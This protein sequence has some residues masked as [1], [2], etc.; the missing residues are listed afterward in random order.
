[1]TSEAQALTDI[2]AQIIETR[3]DETKISPSWIATQA[4]T[5]LDPDHHSIP[6][7]YLA[8]HLEMRQIARGLLRQ[9]FEDSDP[10]TDDGESLQHELFPSLQRRYPCVRRKGDEPEYVR[11]E[12]MTDADIDYNVTRMRRESM[13]KLHHADALIAYQKRRKSA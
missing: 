4:M 5:E 6:L 10:E 7:V 11:L 12:E 2:I 13:A 1:M 9:W 8:A 3:R